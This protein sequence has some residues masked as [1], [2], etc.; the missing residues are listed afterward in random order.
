MVTF[1]EETHQYFNEKGEEYKSGTGFIHFFQKE[2]DSV[3]VATRVATREGV[4]VDEILN[5]WKKNSEEACTHGTSIHLLME[6]YLKNGIIIPEHSSLYD[7]FDDITGEMRKW[8]KAIHSEKILWN[9]E[10]KIAGTADLI[11]DHNKNE[12]SVGDFKTNKAIHFC[13][14]WA[15]RL[16]HPISHLSDCNYNLYSL[17]LSLY[18]HMYS[19]LTG[20][21]GR[22]VF[23]MHL[24]N[25]RW[26]EI[27]AN[28]MKH[29]VEVMLHYYK[30]NVLSKSA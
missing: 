6:N 3:G 20:K 13:S 18:A 30:R 7:S 25:G 5:K 11:I 23:L 2:F 26:K 9:D 14:D 21:M 1:I 16:L 15:E 19:L 8:A 17:Q 28:F 27:T 24:V 12:F 10:Y 4:T 29:E 22:R